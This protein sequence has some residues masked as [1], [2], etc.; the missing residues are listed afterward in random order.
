MS[1][2]RVLDRVR[3]ML[4]LANDR[5][6]SEGERD[7]ALRM[8][9]ATLAK[10]NLD[11][12]M[13]E[14][15]AQKKKQESDEPRQL[16][17]C[18][19]YGRPWARAVCTNVG[20]MLFCNYLYV[21]ATKAKDTRH[22]FIGRHS[23]AVS[24]AI[25]SEFLVNSIMREGKRRARAEGEGNAWFRSFAWGAAVTIGRRV[26]ELIRAATSSSPGTPVATPP[27]RAP[28]PAANALVLA[29]VYASEQSANDAATEQY[30]PTPKDGRPKGRS[31]KDIGNFDAFS[32]GVEYGES[33]S[34]N[35]QL[36]G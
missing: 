34:L 11:L 8:A 27:T 10:Y 31:G 29:S 21:S 26:D 9:H 24:A 25:L 7:N 16:H 28:E 1:T 22:Y 6:A 15:R 13:V 23:N 33:V 19:F 17:P 20:R 12:A 18:T 2:E 36:G 4:A 30:F 5:G 3:K 32:S 14:D 35:R